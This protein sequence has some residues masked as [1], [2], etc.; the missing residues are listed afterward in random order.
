MD[1]FLI[2]TN[3]GKDKDFQVTHQV[4]KLLEQAGKSCMLC[5]KDGHKK[6]IDE[7]V[8]LSL[9]EMEVLL[10]LPGIFGKRIFLF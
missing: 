1:H 8:P 9:G 10:R 4:K 3:D 2:V 7:S 6:I 5:K